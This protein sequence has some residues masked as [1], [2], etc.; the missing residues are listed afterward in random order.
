MIWYD[1]ITLS[2]ALPDPKDIVKIQQWSSNFEFFTVTDFMM[3]TTDYLMHAEQIRMYPSAQKKHLVI[4]SQHRAMD[5][6]IWLIA[7]RYWMTFHSLTPTEPPFHEGWFDPIISIP[8][9]LILTN[10]YCNVAATFSIRL[11]KDSA[12]QNVR[13]M[14]RFKFQYKV[15]FHQ[16]G[17]VTAALPF[18]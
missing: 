9:T 17:A 18:L 1:K 11:A 12:T 7:L 4:L 3:Q 8:W 13:I 10:K 5:N 2:A 14:H 15:G 6:C 16:C